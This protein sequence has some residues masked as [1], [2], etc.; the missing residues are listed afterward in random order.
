MEDNKC[1][2]KLTRV[3]VLPR[4]RHD[5]QYNDIQHCWLNCDTQQKTLDI[6]TLGHNVLGVAFFAECHYAEWRYAECRGA[7]PRWYHDIQHNGVQHNN[8]Q[9][10]NKWNATLYL[11]ALDTDCC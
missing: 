4:G 10:N 2:N 9:H 3:N 6:M 5:T 1:C 11:K 7:P 8:I